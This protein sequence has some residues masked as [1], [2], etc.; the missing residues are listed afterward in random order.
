MAGRGGVAS[1]PGTLRV[2]HGPLVETILLTGEIEAARAEPLLAPDVGIWP[3]EVRWLAEH[4]SRVRAGDRVA[5]FDN[6]TL[7]NQLDVVRA[8]VDRRDKELNSDE[9]QRAIELAEAEF[10]VNQRRSE[11]RKAELEAEVPP[12][13]IAARELQEKEL[14]RERARVELAKA[15]ETL[16]SK[17]ETHR[18]NERSSELEV[19]DEQYELRRILDSLQRLE[20]KAPRDGLLEVVR[21]PRE[22]RL[23][24]AGDTVQPGW[25]V[26]RV[27]DL[28]SLRV[29]AVLFDV[30]DGRIESGLPATV[31]LDAFPDLRFRGRVGEIDAIARQ[32]GRE[33]LRRVFEVVVELEARDVERMRP[34]MSV[35]VEIERDH[36]DV[37]QVPRRALEV[38]DKATAVTLASGR[39]VEVRVGPCDAFACA[40]LEAPAELSEGTALAPAEGAS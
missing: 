21:S 35:Q 2:E 13:L 15:Q 27:P 20:L 26:A 7:A 19:E 3:L 33:S 39:R 30:D 22:E 5:E 8:R 9:S 34:G 31:T 4:G 17:R 14:A 25:T 6:G 28:D 24:Q 37:L 11:L 10:A 12:D 32:V 16:R 23:F 18:A 38:G 29:R 40:L 36:G 1:G